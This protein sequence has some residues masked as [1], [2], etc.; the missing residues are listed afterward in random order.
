MVSASQESNL[1]HLRVL[2]VQDQ[3]WQNVTFNLFL[4]WL[5]AVKSNQPVHMF[6]IEQEPEQPL[7]NQQS[8]WTPMQKL[9]DK[10]GMVMM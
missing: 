7:V 5:V 10:H 6:T 4:K 3:K 2:V 9:Q 8:W 1:S